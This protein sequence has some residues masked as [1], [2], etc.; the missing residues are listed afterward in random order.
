MND[1]M[2][3]TESVDAETGFGRYEIVDDASR[4]DIDDMHGA[5]VVSEQQQPP[6]APEHAVEAMPALPT[7]T[8]SRRERRRA[9]KQANPKPPRRPGRIRRGA[10]LIGYGGAAGL[11]ALGALQLADIVGWDFDIL[12]GDGTKVEASVGDVETT[13]EEWHGLVA[14]KLSSTVDLDI[15]RNLNHIF[16]VPDCNI[17]V[18]ED[19]LSLSGLLTVGLSGIQVETNGDQVTATVSAFEVP[20]LGL[21]LDDPVLPE[22]SGTSACVQK[23]GEEKKD[24]PENVPVLIAGELLEAS[25]QRIGECVINSAND[26]GSDVQRLLSTSIAQTIA[27]I[28]GIDADQVAVVFDFE[29]S[30]EGKQAIKDA[31]ERIIATQKEETDA[32]VTIDTVAVEDCEL[33]EIQAV[34]APAA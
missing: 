33:H 1:R 24:S 23:D 29:D 27:T 19:N 3:P 25:S 7:H 31:K 30:D 17:S 15:T 12:P 21:P 13:V 26:E 34:L 14:A 22:G 2:I 4:A 10:K 18:H 8:P 16:P 20:Q 9:N 5:E 28:R 11:M 32:K 6:V